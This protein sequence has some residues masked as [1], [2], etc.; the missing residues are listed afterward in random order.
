MAPVCH[1]STPVKS[2]SV[3]FPLHPAFDQ[4]I[5][6]SENL[7]L[8]RD[9]RRL[10]NMREVLWLAQGAE[11][12]WFEAVH[13][14]HSQREMA[15]LQWPPSMAHPSPAPSFRSRSRAPSKGGSRSRSRPSLRRR[16]SSPTPSSPP[17]LPTPAFSPDGQT[18]EDDI[19][20]TEDTLSP[21]DPR[22][23]TPTLHA[24][25]VSEILSLR[26]EIENKTKAID[27]LEE[28]LDESRTENETL[29]TNL[30]QAT[31]EGRSL[32][33]QIQLLEGGTSSAMAELA[34][35]RDE[36]VENIGDVRKRLE[37]AQKKAR[38]REEDV[39]RTQLLWSRDQDS[40]ADER[41]ALERKI[42]VVE[43]R[44]KTV[45]NE[46]AAAQEVVTIRSRSQPSENSDHIHDKNKESDS[47]SVASSS[48]GRRRTSVTTLSSEEGEEAV[49]FHNVRYSVMSIA[50]GSKNG[51]GL[52]LAEELDFEEEDEDEFVPSDDELPSSPEALPEE[53]PMSVHSQGS[54]S[55]S[56]KARKILGLSLQSS[57]LY[58]PTALEFRA[59]ELGLASPVKLDPAVEYRDIGI[60]Y[61]PPPSPTLEG[62]VVY[63]IVPEPME[64]VSEPEK[65]D[66]QKTKIPR[67]NDSATLPV[68]PQMV[69]NS[70]Q[71]VDELPSPPWTPNVA[72]SP[73]PVESTPEPVQMK[74]ASTQ[75]DVVPEPCVAQSE[76]LSPNASSKMDIPMI[77]IHPPG[78]EPSSPR[79]SVVL[80]PQTKNIACQA[81]F[82]A[83]ADCRSVAIQTEEIRFDQRPVRLPASLLPSAI[84]D[85]LPLPE[86]EEPSLEFCTVPPVPPRSEKRKQRRLITDQPTD[87]PV[88]PPR[89]PGPDH[90]QA[91]PGNNDNGPLSDDTLSNIRRPLR[92]SSL[93]AGFEN[94]SDDEGPHGE[95]DVFTDDELLN[96]PFAA[97]TVSRGKLITSKSRPSLDGMPL[98]EIDEQLSSPESRPPNIGRSRASQ[99]S[100]MTSIRQPGMRKLAMISSGT[101][102]HQK[103]RA[104][105]PSEPSLESGSTGSSIAPPFPVPI[106]LSSRNLPLNGSDG[107]PSPTRSAARQFSDR[108]RQSVVRRP[109]LR[110]VRSAAATSQSDIT[111]RPETLSSPSRSTATFSPES[112]AYRP[113]RP[114]PMP[115]DEITAP[116]ERYGPSKRISHRTTPSQ[117]WNHEQCDRKDSTGGVQPTSVVDAIAQT[118]VGEWM[119]KYVRRRK[120]FGMGESKETWEGK[121]PDDVSANITNSGVR[122]KR[123]V[124]LAPYEGSI[125]WSSKQPTSGPALL[126]KSGRK[127]TI[128][129][130]LDVKDDNPIPKGAGSSIP[131]NRSILVLTPQ[132]ALKFTA[133]TI[134]R[135]YVWLTALSFLSHSA[136]GLQE[137]AALPPVP[138]EESPTPPQA[139]LRRNPIR[140]SIRVAKGRPRPVPKDKRSF[141]SAGAPA[142]VPEIPGGSIDLAA[143]APHVPRF[144]THSRKRS[145]TAPRPP[146]L[147][148]LRSFSSAGTMPSSHSG[149][150]AG[151]SE[152][153]FPAMQPPAPPPGIGSRRSSISR[154]TSEASG[155]AS[156]GAGSNMF[157]IGT[158]RMEAFIDRHAEQINRPRAPPRQRHVR[159]TSSQWSERR[160]E[161]DTPSVHGSEFS[162]RPDDPWRGF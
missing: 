120:S 134:E 140:D 102:A 146:A 136:I 57:D 127:F 52:N 29:T 68:A 18:D 105:S 13:P 137:L 26:R 67:T 65:E 77:A 74:S 157:D 99:R 46:V 158:V 110:R 133:L 101:A 8:E 142:P 58:S 49:I 47:A 1:W 98:P 145:N 123:W 109:T 45:L 155:R 33:H 100:G 87:H 135:H 92:S 61:S 41:R 63:D 43:G 121:N 15:D 50:P 66:D 38:S 139:S 141:N 71:T 54:H 160:Y 131:F 143:D 85:A 2:P 103:P 21:F 30:S 106:R 5:A 138:Q 60:Q 82:R 11:P 31:W 94:N 162:Y 91:Y 39:E 73:Q 150:T 40:W 144:S 70:C 130:V 107:P 20:I 132:R 14:A 79:N 80:P 153:H 96:R 22:R 161:F 27:G 69:S 97:Y 108:G 16:D 124:W 17:G 3:E 86:P 4:S 9:K 76:N 44:L 7:S 93:F 28:S 56:F 104:R 89:A 90:V 126:G 55:V 88:K 128:Q 113:Y 115:C 34:R 83:I 122:H 119:F 129:S 62:K 81:N 64:T 23:I 37:Q 53:R 111:E 125:M 32:K 112:P 148:A 154:R 78:S 12:R 147:H 159:K 72:D 59:R 117:T 116:R 118:M 35:E 84:Q 6:P 114:P 10:Q 75:T 149:T 42:H 156:S 51:S 25:L 36:A 95:R 48:L 152:L 19:D 151:S 24:S